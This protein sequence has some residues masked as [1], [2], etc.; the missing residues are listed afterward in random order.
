MQRHCGN[1]PK[2]ERVAAFD[3]HLVFK[4]LLRRL[5]RNAFHLDAD[6]SELA[7]ACSGSEAARAIRASTSAT[8]CQAG[9]RA[10]AK[11]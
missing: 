8:A 3:V 4:L 10:A 11:G 2:Q 9:G 1:S 7:F 5:A 6:L